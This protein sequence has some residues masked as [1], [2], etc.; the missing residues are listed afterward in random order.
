MAG[1]KDGRCERGVGAEGHAVVV[2]LRARVELMDSRHESRFPD[3]ETD[4]GG[5]EREFREVWGRAYEGA[6]EG[7]AGFE[8]G[9]VRGELG[10]DLEWERGGWFGGRFVDDVGK[11]GLFDFGGAVGL[12]VFGHLEGFDAV[13]R[14]VGR[15]C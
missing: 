2:E 14:T 7:I 1:V 15:R 4:L 12:F 13:N 10:P 6:D 11:I 3:L 5:E 8:E 9:G